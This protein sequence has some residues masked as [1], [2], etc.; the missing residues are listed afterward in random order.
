MVV[1]VAVVLGCVYCILMV[2]SILLMIN[3][4][5]IISYIASSLPSFPLFLILVDMVVVVLQSCVYSYF[6][7]SYVVDYHYYFVLGLP[8]L[9]TFN[10]FFSSLVV[11][12]FIG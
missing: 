7:C 4:S 2:A 5:H 11:V 10:F 9:L 6:E 3:R 8:C 12:V 1:V